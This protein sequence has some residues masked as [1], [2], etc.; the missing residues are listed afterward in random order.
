[1]KTGIVILAAGKSTRMKDIKQ[2]LKVKGKTLLSVAIEKALNSKADEVFCILGAH[3]EKINAGI[4]HYPVQIIVN[5]NYQS[6][7]SSSIT[8]GIS[9]LEKNRFDAAL[10]VLADQPK[11]SVEYL[12]FL[13][14]KFNQ[15]SE[16][17][18]CSDYEG[19][20]GVPAIFPKK[21]FSDLCLLTGDQGAGKILNG[22]NVICE[23]V[24][25]NVDLMDIDTPEDY[26]TF[27]E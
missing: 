10:I 21:Y 11:I 12:D 1:M 22:E 20:K 18:Y 7:I 3:F 8:S 5:R 6:G 23:S 15:N 17:I 27:L 9:H 16:V 19:S 13:M 26:K 25:F 2:N 4:S 14:E 24:N